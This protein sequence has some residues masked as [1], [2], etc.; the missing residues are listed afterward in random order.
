[1]SVL[2]KP[3]CHFWMIFSLM[4]VLSGCKLLEAV[5]EETDRTLDLT[6]IK[7][8]VVLGGDERTLFVNLGD[9]GVD[10]IDISDTSAPK[11][12]KNYPTDD[13]AYALWLHDTTLFV[14]N[15]LE[16]VSLLDVT[17]PVLPKLIASISTDDDNA[18]AV[19]VSDDGRRVAI[20]T[21]QGVLLYDLSSLTSPR[22][23]DRYDTNGTV[24]D[25][26]FSADATKIYLAN[27]QYGLEVLE[28]SKTS[29]LRELDALALEGS[30]CDIEPERLTATLYMATLTSAIKRIDVR[31]PNDLQLAGTYDAH[32][33]SLLWD[34][35][36][37]AD[38]RR[39]YLAKANR[40]L[41]ILD[42]SDPYHPVS[43]GS[44]DTNGTARGVAI[45]TPETRAF[46]ADGKEGLK[47]IDI[48]DKKSPRRVS[49]LNF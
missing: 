46:V 8:S 9:Q 27:F 43:L 16:G 21:S 24:Y 6:L 30:S 4:F 29:R 10:I 20:G 32:D 28:V 12:L 44:F 49:V 13:K 1:M 18:T 15:G 7:Q 34:I 42:N 19:S 37:S 35:A 39:L 23:L 38:F 26:R 31:D 11:I 41:G 48:S 22:Y 36:P 47:V 33:G 17:N 3:F 45:N 5:D 40:G 2:Y 14:A 25:L